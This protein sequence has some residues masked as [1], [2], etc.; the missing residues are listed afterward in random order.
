VFL[1]DTNALSEPLKPV[2]S[3][4]FVER[5][6]AERERRKYASTV[7]VMELRYGCARHPRGEGWWERIR[8]EILGRVDLVPVDEEIAR[9]AGELMAGVRRRGRPRATEDILIAATALVHR[10]TLVTHHTRDFADL[11][12]LVVE[13]WMGRPRGYATLRDPPI[14]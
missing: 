14:H 8:E 2:P 9:R 4:A 6:R 7:S 5:L 10:L 13:D 11:P 1:L 12:G 3:R